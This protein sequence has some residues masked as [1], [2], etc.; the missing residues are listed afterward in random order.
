MCFAFLVGDRS[1]RHSYVI[2]R[3]HVEKN[4]CNPGLQP[5][6]NIKKKTRENL[7]IPYIKHT[8]T[9]CHIKG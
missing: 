7:R 3:S 5:K 9:C 6:Q 1:F 2:S 4:V 8:I